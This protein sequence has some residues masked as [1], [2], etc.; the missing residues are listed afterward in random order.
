MTWSALLLAAAVL[1]GTGPARLGRSPGAPKPARSRA[2]PLAAAS[3]FDVLAA[4]LSAG[5]S[6]PAAVAA[7]AQLAPAGLAQ[8]LIRAGNLLAL[9]AD[10]GTAWDRGQAPDDPHGVALA[11]MARRSAESGAA[12]AQGA[13]ELAD[14]VRSAAG[15]SAEAAAGRASVLIAGPLGV[16][17]LPAFICL[18]VVP[19]VVGLAGHVLG[20]GFS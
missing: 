16:C 2:D 1:I 9:G 15:A 20:A 13:A 7:A 10:A 19:V 17:F 4:C 6:T 3:C 12:L 5:M 18:G 8:R 11:R 14:Q